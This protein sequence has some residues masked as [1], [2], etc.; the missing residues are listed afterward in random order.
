MQQEPIFHNYTFGPEQRQRFDHDG[1]FLLPG[2][3]TPAACHRLTQSLS[4]IEAMSGTESKT[5]TAPKSEVSSQR[6]VSP[7]RYAAEYDSYLASL[8]AH[9]Q[10]LSLVRTILGENVRFDH[11]VSLNRPGGDTGIGWHSHG[12]AEDQPQSGFI[13]IFFYVTGFTAGDGGLKV[14]PGSHLYRDPG[15]R[16]A[17]DE[18]LLSGWLANKHHPH[19][20]QAL[21]I[22]SLEAPAGSVIIMWTHAA[23]AVTPRKADSGMRSTVVYAYRNPG[24][25]SHARWITPEFEQHPF[26][27]TEDL[28]SL[29]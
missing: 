9:P 28:M 16:A 10:M 25:P 13:R 1:H 8:I 6:D 12:Y 14:V 19:T 21:K 17:T 11:C 29:Y 15:L 4:T 26:P 23:H 20:G 3:L 5:E 7:Q 24:A 2:L 18:E 22:E 27:G